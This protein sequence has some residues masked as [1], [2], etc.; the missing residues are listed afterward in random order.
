MK[1]HKKN[2]LAR[3][4]F[5]GHDTESA[6]E[7][8]QQSLTRGRSGNVKGTPSFKETRVALYAALSE[9]HLSASIQI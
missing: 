5:S 8:T 1:K 3:T 7:V 4:K 2:K 6:A 9:F